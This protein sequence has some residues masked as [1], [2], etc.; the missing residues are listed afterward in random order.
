MSTRFSNDP[1]LDHLLDA[2]QPPTPLADATSDAELLAQVNEAREGARTPVR[3]AARRTATVTAAVL[4]GLGGVG[5]AAAAVTQASW[6]PWAKDPDVILT[7]ELPSG[8][9]CELRLGNAETTD[10]DVLAALR[11]IADTKDV[12]ALADVDA[13]IAELRANKGTYTDANGVEHDASYGTP[14]YQSPDSEFLTATSLAVSQ[15]IRED[16]KAQGLPAGFGYSGESLC[17]EADW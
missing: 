14:Y 16:L 10:A 4:L 8:A 11:E 2:S 17:P 13:T 9:A 12:L 3:R 5:A 1:E 15:L 6:S 7:F